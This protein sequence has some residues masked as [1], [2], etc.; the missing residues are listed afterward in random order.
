MS[1][2][3]SRSKGARNEVAL[4][5]L[6][7]GQRIPLSGAAGGSFVGDIL[8]PNGKRIECKVRADGFRQ[9]YAWIE[10]ADA[11][12]VRADRKD[13]LIVL[14]LEDY[15][16]MIGGDATDNDSLLGARRRPAEGRTRQQPG[17]SRGLGEERKGQTGS[18]QRGPERA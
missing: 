9:L 17:D 7:G 14:R 11:L 1:G 12:A 6:L 15:M 8:L 13:W 4:A 3:R 5:K 10:N 16:E 18:P 2:R